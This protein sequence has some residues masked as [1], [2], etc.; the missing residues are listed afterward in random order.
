MQYELI[1]ELTGDLRESVCS[2]L[3]A[4]NRAANPKFYTARELPE[5]APRPLNI[6]AFDGTK[7]VVGGLIGQTQFA[8]L[9]VSILAV[10][11]SAR[12]SGIGRRL[13]DMAEEEAVNRGCQYAY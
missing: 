3:R 5:N 4:F 1:G 7:S 10:D 8:W 13:M 6:V 12:R 11:E 9:E 2:I